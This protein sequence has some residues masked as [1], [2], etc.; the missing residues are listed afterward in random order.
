MKVSAELLDLVRQ[1]L[2]QGALTSA[3]QDRIHRICE[4]LPPG[5]GG[6][7]GRLWRGAI[8]EK[9]QLETLRSGRGIDLDPRDFECWSHARGGIRHLLRL[10]GHQAWTECKRRGCDGA[11]RVAVALSR[12]VEAAD[13]ILDLRAFFE[14]L[15]PQYQTDGAWFNYVQPEQEVILRVPG[16]VPRIEPEDLAEYWSLLDSELQSPEIGETF[17]H[18]SEELTVEALEGLNEC[19]CFEVRSGDTIYPLIHAGTHFA[20]GGA[21]R[22]ADEPAPFNLAL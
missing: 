20:I 22:P 8:I 13:C 18:D 11:G 2:G 5:A 12:E 17:F 16:G 14:A 1:H 4:L 10:R 21:P 7:G 9:A 15:G 19:G 3:A 6:A